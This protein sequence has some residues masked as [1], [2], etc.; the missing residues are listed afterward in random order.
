M[1]F[2]SQLC[3]Q[4]INWKTEHTE[5]GL[6]VQAENASQRNGQQRPFTMEAEQAMINQSGI[7]GSS[8]YTGTQKPTDN[9]RSKC[10]SGLSG[11]LFCSSQVQITTVQWAP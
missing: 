7:K 11:R 9:D 5:V 10:W 2:L 8:A 6:K 4:T 3:E 1:H